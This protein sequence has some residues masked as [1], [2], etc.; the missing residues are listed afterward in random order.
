MKFVV[1]QVS[2]ELMTDF[3]LIAKQTLDIYSKILTHLFEQ[4]K[5]K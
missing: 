3:K 2:F 4:V 5:H 1:N